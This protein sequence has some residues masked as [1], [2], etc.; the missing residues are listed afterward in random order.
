MLELPS[1]STLKPKSKADELFAAHDPTKPKKRASRAGKK[2]RRAATEDD[3]EAEDEFLAPSAGDNNDEQQS[4]LPDIQTLKLAATIGKP[5][6][7]I[8]SGLQIMD[9]ESDGPMIVY[10]GQIYSCQWASGIGSDLLFMRRPDNASPGYKPLHSFKEVDIL[11]I[12]AV[13]LV[14]S[15]ATIER[16]QD[17]TRQS[18]LDA[19]VTN[20]NSYIQNEDVIRQARFLGRIAEIKARR[21]EPAGN[22]KTLA[23][24]VDKHPE[25]FGADGKPLKRG[26]GGRGRAARRTTTAPTRSTTIATTRSRRSSSIRR[27][28]I[29]APTP[30]SWAE[31]EYGEN[32]DD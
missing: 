31:L 1:E 6:G 4:M 18:G 23:E 29:S 8:P 19:P 2:R 9:L 21:G 11:G 27:G 13:K 14:A 28:S 15:P 17:F 12:S 3:E 25:N 32:D 10:Q 24:S 30:A 26:R 7:T 20:V 16:R 5:S 22:L